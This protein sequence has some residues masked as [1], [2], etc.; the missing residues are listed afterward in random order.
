MSETPLQKA[1]LG[2]RRSQEPERPS[3]PAPERK[4]TQGPKPGPRLAP[5]H[6][7]GKAKSVDPA[8]T[9]VKVF[10]RRETHR[11]AGR[12][13]EDEDG[14]DFSDLVERLLREYLGA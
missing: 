6:V 5:P 8:Y 11:A 3:T 14:G 9:A 10:V 1:F 2:L 4:G 13:W 12:K 7:L